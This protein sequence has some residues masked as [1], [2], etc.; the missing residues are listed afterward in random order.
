LQ[1][2]KR[3]LDSFIVVL[4]LMYMF[5]ALSAALD[6]MTVATERPY[7]LQGE[8]LLTSVGILI[9]ISSLMHGMFFLKHRIGRITTDWITRI[10]F[11]AVFAAGIYV[12]VHV[13]YTIPITPSSDSDTYFKLGELLVNGKLLNPESQQLREYVS[14]FPH[15]IGFPMLVLKPVFSCLGSVSIPHCM[16]I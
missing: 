5:F 7:L 14:M 12:R 3:T 8:I 1:L 11:L 16:Q 10:W 6:N 15:T 2:F 9:A 13:I 4:F